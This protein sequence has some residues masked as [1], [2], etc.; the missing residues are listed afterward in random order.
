MVILR[1]H[2]IAVTLCALLF[3]TMLRIDCL[4]D[5]VQPRAELL[6]YIE[7]FVD[8]ETPFDLMER[9]VQEKIE[10]S[11]EDE[12]YMIELLKHKDMMYRWLA[13]HYMYYE[14]KRSCVNYIVEL[15]RVE[16]EPIIMQYV[17][18]V[19][20][21][22]DDEVSQKRLAEIALDK[23]ISNV[24]RYRALT[25]LDVRN[26]TLIRNVL[27]KSFNDKDN[28]VRWG[29]CE[30]VR[31]SAI[32]GYNK[33]VIKCLDDK[34]P[35]L[36]AKAIEAC[37]RINE[38][39][40]IDKYVEGKTQVRRIVKKALDNVCGYEYC[41]KRNI[42]SDERLLI[43]LNATGEVMRREKIWK[44][45]CHYADSLI[46]PLILFDVY[47]NY[48]HNNRYQIIGGSR[49]NIVMYDGKQTIRYSDKYLMPEKDRIDDAFRWVKSARDNIMQRVGEKSS[50]IATDAM[51]M[52]G[53]IICPQGIIDI[54]S[55]DY[56]DRV[57]WGTREYFD[58]FRK[59][60]RYYDSFVVAWSNV[61]IAFTTVV[62]SISTGY[63][64][65]EGKEIDR[66]F[67]V[68]VDL[69]YSYL[70][71]ASEGAIITVT[72]ECVSQVQ[73][74]GAITDEKYRMYHYLEEIRE[75]KR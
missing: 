34:S 7:E 35:I 13:L 60:D 29:A 67:A 44:A 21:K 57:V 8:M 32:D 18:F 72:N 16:Q 53:G 36:C 3:A 5:A 61:P 59:T 54:K 62:A 71:F 27:T 9:G 63:S 23:K 17:I 45:K 25:R 11:Q 64:G 37:G 41:E 20:S 40:A 6:R 58:I 28:A 12:L 75:A 15:S 2:A 65:S 47:V 31:R 68:A 22:F 66:S 55:D 4:G 50:N 39:E 70:M 69:Y 33:D 46:E 56:P 73:I 10:F 30:L 49:F 24:L 74:N 19:L 26:R 1:K 14:N 48:I 52:T 38:Y 42:S 51:I 43:Y